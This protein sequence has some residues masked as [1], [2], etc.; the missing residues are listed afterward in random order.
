MRSA[1]RSISL[2]R[3]ATVREHREDRSRRDDGQHA[4]ARRAGGPRHGRRWR[5]RSRQHAPGEGR[6]GRRR[7]IWTGSWTKGATVIA[8]RS[9]RPGAYRPLHE[10]AGAGSGGERAR[11][12]SPAPSRP[13]TLRRWTGPTASRL[14]GIDADDRSGA[15][16]SSAGDVNGDGFDDLIVGAPYCRERRRDELQRARAMWCS[17]RRAGRGR[18]S[19]DLATL[20][21][22][23][24]FRLIG[25]GSST[26]AAAARSPRLGT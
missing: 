16:V 22:T 20:D 15:S 25:I 18:P 12:S 7:Q 11:P 3:P 13:S 8:I 23:N 24:G 4:G 5:C 6:C 1:P 26:I 17:A 14:I 19:L 2:A 10:R 21:G 9:A